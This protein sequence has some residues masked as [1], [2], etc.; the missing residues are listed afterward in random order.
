MVRADVVVRAATT[1]AGPRRRRRRRLHVEVAQAVRGEVEL[2]DHRRRA[3]RDVVAVADVH[4]WRRRTAR[5]PPCRRRS[6]G[7]RAERAQPGPGQVGG[8]DEPVVPGADDD[9]VVVVPAAAPRCRHPPHLLTGPSWSAGSVA[10]VPADRRLAHLRAPDIARCLTRAQHRR[11]AAR[12]DRAARP[13]PAVQHRPA[14]RRAGRRR[15]PSSGSATRST[16]GCCRRSPTRSRTS[17]PGR[18]ARSGCRRRRCSPCSTTSAA[19]SR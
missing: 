8:G 7:P 4:A 12:G 3:E 16:P 15:P 18:R 5:S 1:A 11:A 17:T 2:V 10:R 13:A 19:A 9:R 14:D 6:G